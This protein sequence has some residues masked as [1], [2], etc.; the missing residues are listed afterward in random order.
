MG[1]EGRERKEATNE[2][3]EA[4]DVHATSPSAVRDRKLKSKSG[5]PFNIVLMIR[6]WRSS[7]IPSVVRRRRPRR[8]EK[9]ES[10]IIISFLFKKKNWN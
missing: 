6:R 4:N 8:L 3:K 1:P 10:F 7:E 2:R 9:I 5:Q